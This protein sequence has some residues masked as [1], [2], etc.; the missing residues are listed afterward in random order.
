MAKKGFGKFVL[1]G[2]IGAAAGVLFA[3]KAGTETRKELKIKFDEFTA[4][5]KDL[6]SEEIK[7]ELETKIAEIR[8]DLDNL[9]KEEVLSV[10]KEKGQEVLEK[11]EELLDYAIKKGTPFLEK[12]AKEI[13]EV[14]KVTVDEILD[15][16]EEP[17][18]KAK[19]KKK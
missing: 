10:A 11:S 15:R 17:V 19:A 7:L 1:G 6:D 5:L 8:A 3:P 13:T 9:D 14:V 4:K 2:L 18:K 16:D 12:A